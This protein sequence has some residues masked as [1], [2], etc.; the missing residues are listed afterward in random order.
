MGTDT[1]LRSWATGVCLDSNNAGNAY[2]IGCNGG[3][4]QKWYPGGMGITACGLKY[5][6]GP[7]VVLRD[8]ATNRVLANDVS[9]AVYTNDYAT[10]N[11]HQWWIM[12]GNNNVTHFQNFFTGQCLQSNGNPSIFTTTCSSNFQDWKQGF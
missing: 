8:D 4:Y 7:V 5:G 1:I 6:C 12:T 9:G 3:L 2:A 10:N 11:H